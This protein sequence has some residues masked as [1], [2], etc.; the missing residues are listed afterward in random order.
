[1]PACPTPLTTG[2]IIGR[3]A[4][5]LLPFLGF[6]VVL[7]LL[8]PDLL[9]LSLLFSRI[10]LYAFGGGFAS[11]P[12]MFHEVVD[13]QG[14]MDSQ[15]FLNGIALGQVT[16]GPIVITATFIG[17]ML[18]GAWGGVVGTVSIFAPS[19]ILLAMAEP[20]YLHLR[21]SNVVRRIIKG[22]LITFVGL[23]LVTAVKFALPIPW[24]VPRILLTGFALAALLNKVD[25]LWVV[26]AGVALS[27]VIFA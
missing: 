4:L 16:P 12:I 6:F 9:N 11:L 15:T 23:I 3:L 27:I 10:D 17:Y 7:Y 21:T 18:H 19:F 2:G 26:A 5:L 24:D 25:I 1:M 13:V 14:W 20:F 8:N 22:V